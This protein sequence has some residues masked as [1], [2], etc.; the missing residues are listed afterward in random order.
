MTATPLPAVPVSARAASILYMLLGAGFGIGTAV[1]LALLAERGE[2]PMTPWGFRSLEGP[3]SR[4]GES[5]TYVFGSA[6]VV[7]CALDVATGA[8]LWRGR[9]W[10]GRL[11]LATSPIAFALAVGFSLPFLLIGVPL[12][13]GLVAAAWR[14][15]R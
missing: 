1:T 7:V 15:L 5:Q 8:G 10:A 11:G 3:L 6:L 9:R 4:A 2:L 12:R 13:A 14:R